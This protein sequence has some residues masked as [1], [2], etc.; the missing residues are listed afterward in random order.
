M[1]DTGLIKVDE[2]QETSIGGVFACG[3]NSSKFRAVATAVY[4]GMFTGAMVNAKLLIE[5]F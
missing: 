1:T 2:S 5:D 4:T 3:D